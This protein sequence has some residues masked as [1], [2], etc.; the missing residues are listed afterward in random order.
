MPI[1]RVDIPDGHP[2]ELRLQLKRRLDECIARTWAKDHIFIAVHEVPADDRT[3]IMTVDLRPG[4]GK[5]AERAN[6]LYHEVL[7][8]LRD[9]VGVDPDRFVLLIREFPEWAFVVDGG[10]SL[11]PLGQITPALQAATESE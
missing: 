2:R 11:P 3:V 9:T 4:R 7:D 6:A 10:K 1:I 5:E 8:S